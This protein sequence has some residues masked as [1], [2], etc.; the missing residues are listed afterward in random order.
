MKKIFL[1]FCAA[2]VLTGCA[3]HYVGYY[4]GKSYRLDTPVK[5]EKEATAAAKIKYESEEKAQREE[6][7]QKQKE[8]L[9]AIWLGKKIYQTED[10]KSFVIAILGVMFLA[11]S[12]NLIELACSAGLPVIFTQ[13]LA[14]ND[15]STLE[16][17]IYIF[18]YI[19][20]FMI[21]DLIVFAIA[22]KTME[23]TGITTKYT[24]YSHLIGGLL[25]FIIGILL[26]VKPEWLMFNF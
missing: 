21:D 1:L 22:V 9:S 5:T 13:V 25:M 16:Y 7:Q 26:I 14:M 24:K 10:E 12:V 17:W 2:A 4:N 11:I 19:F 6:E 3:T 23:L 8:R 20:F 18:I 15:L